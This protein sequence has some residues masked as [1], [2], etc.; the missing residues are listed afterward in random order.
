MKG[1]KFDIQNNIFLL[2]A[3]GAT[4]SAVLIYLLFILFQSN[5]GLPIAVAKF[6]VVF[7]IVI[8]ILSYIC[9]FVSIKN[10]EKSLK[11]TAYFNLLYC[12]LTI[13]IV[14]MY[15]NELTILGILYFIAEKT[16]VIPLALFELKLSK[17]YSVQ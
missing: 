11:I 4:V 5:F 10:L 8:A 3:I 6:L 16:I 9:H 12:F 2:D 14:V 15:Y 13:T 1:I 7:P 17:I